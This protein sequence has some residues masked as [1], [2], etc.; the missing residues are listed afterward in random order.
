M[1][2]ISA[3]EP[4]SKVAR[5]LVGWLLPWLCSTTVHV[6]VVLALA[7]SYGWLEDRGAKP[8]A[9]LLASLEV[10][11]ASGNASILYTSPS[12]R[13]AHESRMTSCA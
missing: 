11:F 5:T 8:G 1:T 2:N 7:A 9:S 4:P 12:P 10:S 13:D 3:V 6:L